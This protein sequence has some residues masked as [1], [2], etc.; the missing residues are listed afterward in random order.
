MFQEIVQFA[1]ELEEE[2]ILEEKTEGDAP[3]VIQIRLETEIDENDKIISIKRHMIQLVEDDLEKERLFAL[4]RK[5][6]RPFAGDN[7]KALEGSTALDTASFL[8][9]RYQWSIPDKEEDLKTR[10]KDFDDSLK[11]IRNQDERS[12]RRR[13]F[14][15]E[16]LWEFAKL[17]KNKWEKTYS[18]KSL[19]KL[20]GDKEEGKGDEKSEE[21]EQRRVTRLLVE[22]LKDR[23]DIVS[24]VLQQPDV[25]VDE[26][27]IVVFR[28]SESWK[29]FEALLRFLY[30]AYCAK[31]AFIH[32]K[33]FY[34][35]VK[36]LLCGTENTTVGMPPLFNNKSANKPFVIH[37]TRK[38]EENI[39]TC[40]ECSNY[41]IRFEK[42]F[43]KKYQIKLFPLFIDPVLQK[44]EIKILTRMKDGSL[45]F[46]GFRKILYAVSREHKEDFTFYL[47]MYNAK[48]KI[49]AFDYISGYRVQLEHPLHQPSFIQGQDGYQVI[50]N[51][52]DVERELDELLD[53]K[54]DRHYFEDKIDLK[55]KSYLAPLVYKYRMPIFN[56]VYRNKRDGFSLRDIEEI[57]SVQMK[58]KLLDP[59]TTSSKLKQYV[60]RFLALYEVFSNNF[61]NFSRQKGVNMEEFRKM[62][63]E[64]REIIRKA[65]DS[66]TIDVWEAIDGFLRQKKENLQREAYAYLTGQV[67]YY[68]LTQSETGD[69]SHR[70]LEGFVNVGNVGVLCERILEA[71]N[72]YKHNIGLNCCTFN[73]IM[74]LCLGFW[75]DD[76]KRRL[77]EIEI[78]F[79]AGYFD[80][81][82]FYESRKSQADEG[83]EQ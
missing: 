14:L 36:C 58:H 18:A 9:F 68:I 30:K 42:Y 57:F 37:R 38:R 4:Y 47:V 59:E 64:L 25:R 75:K 32:E 54:L 61:N 7:N 45:G 24:E 31:K 65:R 71:F 69:K 53:N 5:Y 6:T 62:R 39:L 78:P 44:K 35:G 15:E 55:S 63:D 2:E 82:L 11:G 12:R 73:G 8:M 49:L 80:S 83:G 67:V 28:I 13:I 40:A 27:F 51:V 66:K 20:L 50:N 17:L 10:K 48:N 21:K 26:P 23:N 74:G 1:K 77:K 46:E 22:Y 34:T 41:L 3:Q 72:K 16:H 81:N 19:N 33:S 70:L 43:L 52:F 29:S 60:N 79:Y 76:S 56:F